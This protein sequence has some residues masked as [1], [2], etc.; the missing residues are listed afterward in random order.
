M[1][2][3]FKLFENLNKLKNERLE[4]YNNIKLDEFGNLSVLSP[5]EVTIENIICFRIFKKL[6]LNILI[7]LKN[8]KKVHE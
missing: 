6:K 3:F 4:A 5:L 1:K 8:Q 7:E 2:I